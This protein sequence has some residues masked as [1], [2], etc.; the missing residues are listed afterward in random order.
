MKSGGNIHKL[1]GA[2]AASVGDPPDGMSTSAKSKWMEARQEWARVLTDT[3][4]D[5]LRLYCE[6][7]AEMVNAQ[8]RVEEDGAMVISPSG[9]VQKSPWLTKVEQNREFCRKMIA[10][11]GGLPNSRAKAVRPGNLDDITL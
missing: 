2:V 8:M 11:F 7:W 4:R 3:D 9:V 1:P 5:A 10:A 6:A